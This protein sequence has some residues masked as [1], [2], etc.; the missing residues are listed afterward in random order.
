M[1][2]FSPSTILNSEREYSFP[3]YNFTS[4]EYFCRDTILN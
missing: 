1:W 2:G 4:K 3:T